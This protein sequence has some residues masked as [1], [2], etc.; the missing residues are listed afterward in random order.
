[1][2]LICLAQITELI[3]RMRARIRARPD[4]EFQQSLIR[5]AIGVILILYFTNNSVSL[6]L[7]VRQMVYSALTT[8]IILGVFITFST[9]ISL[10]IS[11]I[12]RHLSM[13][14]DMGVLS[15]LFIITGEV[16]TPLIV[17]L[18]LKHMGRATNQTVQIEVFG[19]GANTPSLYVRNIQNILDQL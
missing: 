8:L 7:E 4:S 9:L 5:L 19:V 3:S 12:R 13:A 15:F 10:E 18:M 11:P 17:S 2:K 16:A 1:M 14:L 6:Q